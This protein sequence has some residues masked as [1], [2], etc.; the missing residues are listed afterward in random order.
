MKDIAEIFGRIEAKKIAFFID[1]CYSGS[2]GGRT[3]AKTGIRAGNISG[4]FLDAMANGEGRIIITASSANEVSLEE[5]SLGHGVF[6]Y[7]LLEGL[8]GRGDLDGDHMITLDELYGYLYDR[9]VKASKAF[10]GCQ[11]PVKKGE[12]TGIFVITTY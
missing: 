8:D 6:T 5:T 4:G 12:N 11:H 7:Y 1:A 10:G 9:V 2:I 3:F